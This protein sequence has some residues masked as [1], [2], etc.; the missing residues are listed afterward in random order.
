MLG[1][2]QY[3]RFA[4]AVARS[5][6][7]W[8]VI[9]NEVPIQQYYAEPYDRWEGYEAERLRL[10]RFLRANVRNVVFL[11]TDNHANLVGEVRLRTLE[12]GGPEGTGFLEAVTGPVAT[13][14]QGAR[15]DKQLG[16]PGIGNALA[17]LFLKPQ[18]PRGIGMRCAA[19]DVYSYAQVRVSARTLTITPKDR[20]GRLVR[21]RTGDRCGPFTIVASR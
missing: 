16:A 19:L 14:T 5:T 10:L 21:E 8:K 4:S 20:R 3:A 12:P 15:T 17:A 2:T 1:A 7:T 18:P 13:E 11:A 6:A 9:V